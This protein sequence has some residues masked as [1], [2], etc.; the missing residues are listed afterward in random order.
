MRPTATDWRSV[1]SSADGTKLVA[2]EHRRSDLHLDQFRVHLDPDQRPLHELGLRC[3]FCGRN[4]I[5]GG[6]AF[7]GYYGGDLHLDQLGIHWTLTSAPST[8]I[9]LASP[10][11]RTEPNW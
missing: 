11:L 8:S 7:A 2:V 1:A 5:G 9:G 6:G 10:L 4:Q 3:L